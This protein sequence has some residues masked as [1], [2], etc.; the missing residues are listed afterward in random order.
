MGLRVPGWGVPAGDP[1]L[2]LFQGRVTQVSTPGPRPAEE[3][4]SLKRPPGDTSCRENE[5]TGREPA[6][7]RG[8]GVGA[9][10][11]QSAGWA[12]GSPLLGGET[13]GTQAFIPQ[14]SASDCPVSPQADGRDA[15]TPGPEH[16]GGL[17]PCDHTSLQPSSSGR[18]KGGLPRI[19]AIQPDAA[20]VRPLG[21]QR[22]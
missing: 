7:L 15:S 18:T 3:R 9:P 4:H 20:F 22:C 10:Q 12:Q 1:D 14:G 16:P 21:P 8:V 5:S 2:E 11:R 13:Q 17:Q 6:Q 19:Q